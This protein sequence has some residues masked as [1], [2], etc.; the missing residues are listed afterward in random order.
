MKRID[1]SCFVSVRS[2]A[3]AITEVEPC[4][5]VLIHNAGV[6]LPRKQTTES[7]LNTILATNYFGPFLLTHLLIGKCLCKWWTNYNCSSFVFVITVHGF[8]INT[9]LKLQFFQFK[10][11]VEIRFRF[12]CSHLNKF[13]T[14]FNY[15][16]ILNTQYCNNV[17]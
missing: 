12:Y 5:D 3:V 14:K 9:I 16:V 7:G 8:V 15:C 17:Q 11:N 4:I 6:L 10:S 2:F 13:G 1:L